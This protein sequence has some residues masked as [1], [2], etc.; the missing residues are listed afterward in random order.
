MPNLLVVNG[1]PD[2]ESFCAALVNA[3]ADGSMVAGVAPAILHL[4]DLKFNPVL[5][6]GYRKRTELEPDLV[7]ARQLIAEAKHLVIIYPIWWSAVPALLKGFFDRILLPG[8]AYQPR[9]NSA[10][11]AKLLTG[12]TARLIV[13]MDAPVWYDLLVYRHAGIVSVKVGTLEYC[14]IK[15]VRVTTF[16]QVKFST[17]TK[18]RKWLATVRALGRAGS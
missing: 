1:H 6:F 16:G 3:Y 7:R 5:G 15:P 2:K 12:K 18:R 9:E 17:E 11:H 4:A 10:L 8:F 14:G 13:T